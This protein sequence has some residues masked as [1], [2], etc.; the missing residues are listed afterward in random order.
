M[1]SHI[2]RALAVVACLFVC[3]A[4][5][6]AAEDRVAPVSQ[7]SDDRYKADILLVIAHPD[8]ETGDIAAYLARAIFDQHR[9]VAVVCVTR[10]NAGGNSVGKAHEGALAAEREIEARRALAFLEITNVWFLNGLD[11]P[12]E[13]VL[14]SLEHWDHGSVLGQVV[15]LIRLTRP[16][17][18]FTWLPDPVAGENHADHQAA[19][20]VATEAFDLAADPAAFAEQLAAPRKSLSIFAEGLSPWQPKKL[21]YYSDAYET[22]Y[23]IQKPVPP[24]PFRKSFLDGVGPI[25]STSELSPSRHVPYGRISAEE[26][27]F[28][29]TQEG[30]IGK[31]ALE[32]NDFRNFAA[33][34]H[35]IFGKSL[36]KS[37]I[38]DDV[39]QGIV[40]GAA[41]F[42]PP[43]RQ[44]DTGQEPPLELGG[45]WAF[46]R[47]FWKVH[48]I[49][50]LAQLLPVP[51]MR[52]KPGARI[53]IPLLIHNDSTR[54]HNL[55]L[56]SA[57]PSMWS[58]IT[59]FQ[60]Y[61]VAASGTYALEADINIPE[62]EPAGWKEVI[63]SLERE[64]RKLGTTKMRV[65]VMKP[66]DQ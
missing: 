19:S 14:S 34:V 29:V 61:P 36:V 41:P 27:S 45:A 22:G 47:E 49:E 38:T 18:I 20:V 2:S 51:E 21:Y 50:H 64:E 39:F 30:S 1:S 35:L 33:P 4:N 57:L 32:T 53:H 9:R 44:V 5:M 12:E 43:H 37:R 25:Y 60:N 15:R 31:K 46:Y 28:Y 63:W 3:L 66:G 54:D 52:S 62:S 26:T 23:I 11:T 65:L 10:G 13:D 48:N 42:S 56:K 7:P 24:S 59:P 17:V 8:D 16:E 58:D 55:H 40:P 6:R